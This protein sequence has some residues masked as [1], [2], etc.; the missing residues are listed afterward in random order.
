MTRGIVERRI[1][2]HRIDAVGDQP[3]CCKC[4]GRGLNV[5]HDHLG[6]KRIVG[7]IGARKACQRRIDLDQNEVDAGDAPGDRK[8][9]NPDVCWT[10]AQAPRPCRRSAVALIARQIE[11]ATESMEGRC[12]RARLSPAA[13]GK[14]NKARERAVDV[15]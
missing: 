7:G 14:Q 5:E 6:A 2:Q 1:H 12:E 13:G 11:T 8:A 9:R 10:V 3:G 4:G 15:R